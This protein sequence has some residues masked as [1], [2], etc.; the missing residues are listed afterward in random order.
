MTQTAA[1]WAHTNI[2]K[3]L[4]SLQGEQATQNTP[5]LDSN[6]VVEKYKA[7]SKRLLLFDYDGT[8]TPI[9]KD[10]SAALPSPALI[11]SLQT[12][13][14]DPQNVV[15]IIS[16]RDGEFLESQLG[17]IQNLGMSAEHGCFLRAPGAKEW[18]SLTDD[19]NMDWKKD[20][21]KIFRCKSSPIYFV[22]RRNPS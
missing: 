12:L 14:A 20:V 19:L 7:A 1:V 16:G 13:C 21:L 4:E 17:H 9:V 8:L 3:L 15:Y 22:S 5:P 10:P 11:E 2:L 6:A 18:M